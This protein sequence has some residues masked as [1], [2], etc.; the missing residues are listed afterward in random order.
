MLPSDSLLMN[1]DMRDRK[2]E[3]RLHSL[4]TMGILDSNTEE[5]FD[6]LTRI[7]SKLFQVPVALISL[8]DR[9]RQWFK[10]AC[11]LDIR[12]TPRTDSFCAVAVENWRPLV[13][14]DTLSE[15]AFS[16]PNHA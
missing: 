1:K 11:G 6:R 12:S 5:R 2:E 3:K 10:S 4:Y 16:H 15:P 8:V 14:N 13:V 9:D 7:A